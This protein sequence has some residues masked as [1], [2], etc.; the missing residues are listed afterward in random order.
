MMA[1]L[2]VRQQMIRDAFSPRSLA[3]IG[4]G[5]N[6]GADLR[7]LR[8]LSVGPAPSEVVDAVMTGM[9]ADMTQ[10]RVN[11]DSKGNCWNV[12]QVDTTQAYQVDAAECNGGVIA[13]APVN[14]AVPSVANPKSTGGVCD[15][16]SLWKTGIGSD[17]RCYTYCS[18]DPRHYVELAAG[19]CFAGT[20][21][22]AGTKITANMMILGAVALGAI[23][24]MQ[25]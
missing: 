3:G 20:K 14:S 11:M 8:G 15:D 9:C 13:Q 16:T 4:C 12:C 23:V 24:L 2:P 18:A 21:S 19:D 22:G 10:W 7:S 6:G 25:Q 5:C 1:Q 17:G